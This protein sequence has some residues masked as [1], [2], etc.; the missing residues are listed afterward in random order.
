MGQYAIAVSIEK[1]QY[2]APHDFHDG[3]KPPE[4]ISGGPGGGFCD[5]LA[6]LVSCM[7]HDDGGVCLP[8]HE[9]YYIPPKKYKNMLGSEARAAG[10]NPPSAVPSPV[11]DVLGSWAG[12]RVIVIG[13]YAGELGYK[14]L[15]AKQ[16][17]LCRDKAL[18]DYRQRCHRQNDQI[19]ENYV[20][21]DDLY[22]YAHYFYENV[23]QKIIH[24]FKRAHVGQWRVD[25]DDFAY[26]LDLR[27]EHRLG[28]EYR[29]T[30][31]ATNFMWLTLEDLELF[32]GRGDQVDRNTH[33]LK[34]SWLAKQDL[35]PFIRD[36]LPSF[37]YGEWDYELR[38]QMM[39]KHNI[40]TDRAH[41]RT[42]YPALLETTPTKVV[43]PPPLPT[44]RANKL[45]SPMNLRHI[46]VGATAK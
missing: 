28:R 24:A 16:R 18:D 12:T 34:H 36:V 2:I 29:Q 37:K 15:T 35:P 42:V 14:Y 46:D 22:T 41:N 25:E 21:S 23:S 27:L 30:I 8:F 33:K 11:F 43:P 6:M 20:G 19:D 26:Q 13:D 38:R 9:K 31:G 32:F 4:F 39:V 10:W 3:A 17:K 7:R 40:E 5:A 1:Q 45:P 44:I